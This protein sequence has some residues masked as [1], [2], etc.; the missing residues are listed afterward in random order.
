[1][2]ESNYVDSRIERFSI[3]ESEATATSRKKLKDTKAEEDTGFLDAMT[4]TKSI[5]HG[6]AALAALLAG[7]PAGAA[8]IAGLDILSAPK[9]M[10]RADAKR[11]GK[12]AKAEAELMVDLRREAK[13][14]AEIDKLNHIKFLEDPEDYVQ[15]FMNAGMTEEQIGMAIGVHN[16]GAK[17]FLRLEAEDE[18]TERIID[19]LVL[20]RDEAVSQER[21]NYYT[22]QLYRMQGLTG[23]EVNTAMMLEVDGNFRLKDFEAI[24]K[25]G[26]YTAGSW[27]A[28]QKIRWSGVPDAE[29][30]A[31]AALK[32]KEDIQQISIEQQRRMSEVGTNIIKEQRKFPLKPLDEILLD[33]PP[34]DED[35]F[36]SNAAEMGYNSPQEMINVLITAQQAFT[37]ESATERSAM[38]EAAGGVEEAKKINPDAW[39]YHSPEAASMRAVKL[40]NDIGEAVRQG[41]AQNALKHINTTRDIIIDA[42]GFRPGSAQYQVILDGIKDKATISLAEDGINPSTANVNLKMADMVANDPDLPLNEWRSASSMFPAKAPID[43]PA[44]KEDGNIIDSKTGLVKDAGTFDY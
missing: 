40:A 16:F 29:I 23:E 43:E 35:V 2:A 19:S 32:Y 30:H 39:A 4:D 28:A 15:T 10:A 7:S 44:P 27:H 22:E 31:V 17:E 13:D 6:A 5:V 20:K 36:R 11:E 3:P 14:A 42:T 9:E 8:A 25:E 34:E 37:E 26:N 1:M 38:I 21:K 33:M 41:T 12:I 24:F 18:E